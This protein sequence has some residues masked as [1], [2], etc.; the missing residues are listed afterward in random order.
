MFHFSSG[1]YYKQNPELTTLDVDLEADI[2]QVEPNHG[3]LKFDLPLIR[4][5]MSSIFGMYMIHIHS[6]EIRSFC[7]MK[8]LIKTSSIY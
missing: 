4:Q 7:L 6:S 8:F 3:D 2:Q 5:R 1:V